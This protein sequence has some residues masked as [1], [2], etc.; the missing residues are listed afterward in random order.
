[1]MVHCSGVG[2]HYYSPEA[3]KDPS[4]K[5]RSFGMSSVV[6]FNTHM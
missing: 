3:E 1:M 2:Y 4:N 5:K 6:L